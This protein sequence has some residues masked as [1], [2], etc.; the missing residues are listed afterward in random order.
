MTNGI[1][2][3]FSAQANWDLLSGTSK[4]GNINV[5]VTFDLGR[6]VH[7]NVNG[8]W[9]YDAPNQFH[10]ATWGAALEWTATAQLALV[11]EVFGQIGPPG[12]FV[13]V[14]EPRF[15]AGVRLSPASNLDVTVIYGRNLNGEGANWLTLGFTVGFPAH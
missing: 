10:Y 9:L 1:G 15:Q 8:G 3:G 6:G 2:I 13:S 4:G 11:A 7:L 12:E 14:T 5:P